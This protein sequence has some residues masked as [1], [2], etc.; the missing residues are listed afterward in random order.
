M[1]ISFYYLYFPL[2]LTSAWMSYLAILKKLCPIFLLTI[3]TKFFFKS[4]VLSNFT[5][6]NQVWIFKILSVFVNLNICIEQAF[7]DHLRV[8][9]YC[10]LFLLVLV[11]VASWFFCLSLDCILGCTWN[12]FADLIWDLGLFFFFFKIY[13]E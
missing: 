3:F 12:P 7:I 1:K 8:Y 6:E 9:F 5:R 10:L 11:S 2:F 4:L 13:F